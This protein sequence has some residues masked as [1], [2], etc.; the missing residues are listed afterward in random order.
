MHQLSYKVYAVSL[1]TGVNF[2]M[3]FFIS[4]LQILYLMEN[5]Y[6]KLLRLSSFLL[7][8]IPIEWSLDRLDGRGLPHPFYSHTYTHTDTQ[9]HS[10][11]P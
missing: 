6:M 2:C 11:T 9:I 5:F 3:S 10:M 4:I 7:A 1:A 8:G